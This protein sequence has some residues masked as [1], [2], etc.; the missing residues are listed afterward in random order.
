ML[1]SS[2]ETSSSA[3]L[4][5]HITGL[6]K[7]RRNESQ[8]SSPSRRSIRLHIHSNDMLKHVPRQHRPS[9]WLPLTM[10][11]TRFPLNL[12]LPA[13]ALNLEILLSVDRCRDDDGRQLLQP[14]PLPSYGNTL[15]IFSIF[16]QLGRISGSGMTNA[17][18]VEGCLDFLFRGTG[19]F[20]A[21]S[22]DLDC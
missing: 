3:D 18:E 16:R 22:S 4:L 5:I 21:S 20:F 6:K 7:L 8:S 2:G 10:M 15:H 11:R 13:M 14:F 19:G 17:W 12:V 9:Y 1:P